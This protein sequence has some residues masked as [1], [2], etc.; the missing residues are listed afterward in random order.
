MPGSHQNKRPHGGPIIKPYSDPSLR[1]MK[2]GHIRPMTENRSFFSRL[3][4]WL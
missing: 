3:F 2:H 1:R 4:R